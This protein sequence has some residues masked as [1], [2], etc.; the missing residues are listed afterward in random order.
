MSN[1]KHPIITF[2]VNLDNPSTEQI[3][4]NT[5][6]RTTDVLHP[7]MHDSSPDRGY[8]HSVN[9]KTQFSS[10]FPGFLV[11]ENIIKNDDDTI[12]VYG[13]KATYLKNTYTTGDNPLLSVVTE[14]FES[15]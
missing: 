15:A 1:P 6:A 3:G 4:P 13:Q 11:G 9:H 7:D 8:T 14:T 2:R 5:N 10:F 12:T